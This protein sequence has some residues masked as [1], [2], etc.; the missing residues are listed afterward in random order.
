LFYQTLC[1]I[2]CFV[3]SGGVLHRVI[4]FF[5]RGFTLGVRF[6]GRRLVIFRPA[7]IKKTKFDDFFKLLQTKKYHI[8]AGHSAKS[9]SQAKKELFSVDL[10]RSP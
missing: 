10:R 8:C 6:I 1:F 5:G 2:K 3:L 9:I 7:Q 4:R